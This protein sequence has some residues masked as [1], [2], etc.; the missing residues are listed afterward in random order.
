MNQTNIANM[1][2]YEYIN[3][4]YEDCSIY[5]LSEGLALLSK[6]ISK[7]SQENKELIS[8]HFSKF[9]ECRTTLEN[10][11]L[12]AKAKGLGS[13]LTSELEKAINLLLKKYGA[14]STKIQDDIL[15]EQSNN[16][17]I[18]Y[19]SEF[20]E[21][22]TLKANL[23][24]NVNNFENFVSLYK[25]AHSIYKPY[26]KSKFLTK[27]MEDIEEE[28][29]AFLENVYSYICTEQLNFDEACY[30][31]DLYFE[32]APDM[33]DRKIMNTLLVT[34]KECTYVYENVENV[35]EYMTYLESSFVKFIDHV[36]DDIKRSGIEHFFKC[37]VSLIKR[38]TQAKMVFTRANDTISILKVSPVVRQH[39]TQKM[40]EAKS[41][42]FFNLLKMPQ[43]IDD[44]EE[45]IKEEGCIYFPGANHTIST[46]LNKDFE[47]CT[48]IYLN[49]QH[50][51]RESDIMNIQDILLDHIKASIEEKKFDF[52][53]FFKIRITDVRKCLGSRKSPKN[54]QLDKF[55]REKKEKTVI[56]LGE[57][58]ENLIE[59]SLHGGKSDTEEKKEKPST[60]E[61]NKQT[62]TAKEI[63]KKPKDNKP[64]SHER[65]DQLSIIFMHIFHLLDKTSL[66]NLQDIL[67]EAKKAIISDNVL[68]YFLA[69]F[70]KLKEPE[71]TGAEKEEAKQLSKQFDCIRTLITKQNQ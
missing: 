14:I 39:C 52:Y 55:L 5:E 41:D 54:K 11:Y 66:D 56:H 37:L 15:Q 1:D 51:V 27:K 46:I 71:L 42:A 25:R 3:S 22:F 38:P 48:E 33:T 49:F 59:N 21:I 62:D 2:P 44:F 34:F 64:S 67:F 32:V 23:A 18:Y 70:V 69:K 4:T 6:S 65:I 68:W 10:I 28:V 61:D 53:E 35:D 8:S 13:K 29:A 60:K 19:E 20:A 31:F 12:D 9:I 45:K 30:Y 24:K 58:L 57:E 26:K 63:S 40:I 47:R 16:K 17:R 36:D 43:E 50:I 7:T